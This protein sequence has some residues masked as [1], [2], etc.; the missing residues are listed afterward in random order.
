M[1]LSRIAILTG[2][3]VAGIA[4]FLPFLRLPLEKTPTVGGVEGAAWPVLVFLALPVVLAVTGDR[5]EG[6]GRVAAAV[7]IV[8]S[9][10]AVVFA[11]SKLADALAAA[12]DARDLVG[13]GSVGPGVWILLAGCLVALSGSVFTLSRSVST[14]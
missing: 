7:A 1:H 6:F 12:R 2:A 9:A 3:L 10:I 11:V 4:Q 13:G 14:R 8:S 5:A